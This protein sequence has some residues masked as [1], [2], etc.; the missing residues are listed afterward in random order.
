MKSELL[1]IA[2]QHAAVNTLYLIHISE[3]YLEGTFFAQMGEL[4]TGGSDTGAVSYTH[5]V[6]GPGNQFSHGGSLGGALGNRAGWCGGAACDGPQGGRKNCPRQKKPDGCYD[7]G[8]GDCAGTGGAFAAV[9][10]HSGVA[11]HGACLLYTSRCV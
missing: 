8:N 7:G 1:V 4:S 10:R 11:Q 6:Y 5:L 3:G 9:E 2:D